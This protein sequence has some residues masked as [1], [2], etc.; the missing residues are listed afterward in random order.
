M[1]DPPAH[2]VEVENIKAAT[3]NTDE[4]NDVVMAEINVEPAPTSVPEV[5][6]ANDASHL[7]PLLCSLKPLLLP[8]LLFRHQGLIQL[9]KHTTMVS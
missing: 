1:P 6:E 5:N 7:K 8:L 9:S 4:A 2:Q 3:T